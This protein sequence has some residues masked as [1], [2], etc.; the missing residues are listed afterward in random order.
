MTKSEEI[1]WE[2]LH[3]F[4][5][6]ARNGSARRA[7]EAMRCHY[8]RIIRRISAFE[9][10]LGTRLFEKSSKGY[11]LTDAGLDILSHA[12]QMESEA[13][14]ITRKLQ[15]ADTTLSGVLKVSMTSTIASFLLAEDL[16]DF[17]DQ[18]PDLELE[19]STNTAFVDLSRGEAQVIIR[20][21][22]DPGDQLVGRKFGTYHEAAY[23]T[24][25][26][27]DAHPID[28]RGNGARWMHW[29]GKDELRRY[30]DQTDYPEIDDL[31]TFEDELLLLNAAKASMGFATLPC[32]YADTD[33]MLVRINSEPPVPCLGLWLL[34]HPDLTRNARVRA[35]LDFFA[36]R[37]EGKKK[38]IEGMVG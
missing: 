7:A 3:V 14:A 19:F 28:A 17:A 38:L 5:A 18:H 4:L 20:A 30:V 22:N 26:Y 9:E 11:A 25:E 37:L 31:Q 24:P 33:P 27:L 10:R 36:E 29:L 12:D 21:S 15:G 23:A 35:F 2:D 13:I 32:F 34:T 8:T 6:V 16:R 1:D